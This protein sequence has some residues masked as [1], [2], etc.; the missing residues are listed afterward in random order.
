MTDRDKFIWFTQTNTEQYFNLKDDPREEHNLIDAPQCQ[1]RI[2]E[3]RQILVQELMD[4]EEGY[5]KNGKLIPIQN[6]VKLLQHSC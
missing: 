5:V 4:R 3:L 2:R 1:D 6:P